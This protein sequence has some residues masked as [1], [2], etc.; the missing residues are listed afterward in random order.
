MKNLSG[1]K[2]IEEIIRENKDFFEEA[3]PSEGH[4]E[5]F[6]RKLEIRF[7]AIST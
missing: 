2:T 3:E 5:R 4:F 6:N 1:M 7:Q